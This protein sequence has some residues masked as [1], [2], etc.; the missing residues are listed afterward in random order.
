MDRV[1]K[2]DI[3]ILYWKGSKSQPFE[4]EDSVRV[5]GLGVIN[6]KEA[7]GEPWG[8]KVMVGD[9]ELY[10]IRS[11]LRDH[12][13]NLTRGAQIITQKD[14][15]KIVLLAGV[16]PGSYVIEIGAGSGG[17]TLHLCH[18]VGSNGRVVTYDNNENNLNITKKNLEKAGL[19]SCWESRLKDV[20]DG[21]DDTDAD[22]FIMDIPVAPEVV[23]TALNAVR[24]GGYIVAY[25]PL[26][27][28][29]SGVS[30]EMQSKG[31][32]DISVMDRS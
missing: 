11:S 25:C 26:I 21:V 32:H 7:I 31:M 29:A 8:S 23:E 22:A 1:N 28:Q 13:D 19:A 12:L 10:L 14:T 17:L 4:V 30:R 5:T 27:D 16:G 20:L 15:P 9:R 6:L 3:A 24:P 2:G 18:T